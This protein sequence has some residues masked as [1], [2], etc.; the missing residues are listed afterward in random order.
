MFPA[1]A[2]HPP[3][4]C[5]IERTNLNG[6]PSGFTAKLAPKGLRGSAGLGAGAGSGA[7]EGAGVGAGEGAGVGVGAGAGAGLAQPVKIMIEAT[8]IINGIVSF[9]I[10]SSL[11][12]LRASPEAH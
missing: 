5:T 9:V 10:F 7:G 11:Q 3:P 2:D 6:V 4:I 12:L 1:K 8:A